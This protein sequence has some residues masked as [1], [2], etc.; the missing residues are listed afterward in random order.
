MATGK[1]GAPL[2]FVGLLLLFCLFVFTA[3]VHLEPIPVC[4]CV[5]ILVVSVHNFSSKSLAEEFSDDFA[6]LKK[7]DRI[8]KRGGR[9]RDD[10]ANALD[11]FYK[12][13]GGGKRGRGNGMLHNNAI[14]KERKGKE[15]SD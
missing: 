13:D 8:G 7:L 1:P 3:P 6:D 12:E 14:E 11:S 15:R 10:M 2:C 4:I 9:D 5:V